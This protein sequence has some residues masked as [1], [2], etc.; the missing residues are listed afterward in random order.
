MHLIFFIHLSIDG[1]L[2]GFHVLAFMNSTAGNIPVPVAF[3]MRVFSTYMHRSGIAV[4][5]GDSIFSFL[6]KEWSL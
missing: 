5:Y 3:W 4:S 2:G 1:H 6:K